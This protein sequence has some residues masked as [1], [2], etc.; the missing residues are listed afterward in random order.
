MNG[1]AMR[2]WKLAGLVA[3]AA[4]VLAIP[5]YVVKETRRRALAGPP[6]PPAVTFVGREKCVDCHR[7]AYEKWLGSDHDHAMAPADEQTVLGDFDDAVFEHGGVTSRFYRRDGRYF[8]HTE[9]PGGEPDEFEVRYTFGVE[10]LQQYL[11]PLPGGRL[12]ALSI[13]WNTERE[14]WFHLYPDQEIPPDDWLHWTRNGQNW[15]GMCAECH[16]TNLLK[17]YD[18]GTKTFDSTWSEIDVSCEACHGPGSRHVA[19]A[20]IQPMARPDI[21][22]YGLI[23]RTGGIGARQQVELCAPCH[24]RRTELGDYDHT[25]IDLLDNLLPALLRENLYHADRRA[26]PGI[27]E[28]GQRAVPTVPPGGRVR[29]LRPPLS[30]EGARGQAERRRA[31][32]E[33]PH[34]RAALHGHRLSRGS[35]PARAPSGPDPGNRCAE[36]LQS[37][38]L[39]RRQAGGVVGRR[40]HEVVRPG[41]QAPLRHDSR[42]RPRPNAGGA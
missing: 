27:V 12:Q 10:P 25:R 1:E 11:I 3:M 14:R 40:L 39:S 2:G 38:R 20:E 21:D 41:A 36:R 4:I 15:N 5:L 42:R 31:V 8:V 19:W 9:G 16:S 23:I 13:A 32:R 29:C 22:D 34:A 17:G 37:R 18:P 26:Q 35:Q 33:V 24:S 28:A 6:G 30:Q 7:K